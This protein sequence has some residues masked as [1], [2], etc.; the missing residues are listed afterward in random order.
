MSKPRRELEDF[1]DYMED[2]LRDNDYKNGWDDMTVSEI[3][4]RMNE[5]A[6]EVNNTYYAKAMHFNLDWRALKKEAADV[7]NFC[8][9]LADI[10]DKRY[11]FPL[12]KVM[13]VTEKII[14]TELKNPCPN[15]EVGN[16]HHDSLTTVEC[17][18]CGWRRLALK[19]DPL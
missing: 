7:A 1:A 18:H 12:Q 3:I 16:L 6:R 8:M 10:I 13:P 11:I 15:C 5:E 9:M 14:L 2:V 19:D 17:S 4:R